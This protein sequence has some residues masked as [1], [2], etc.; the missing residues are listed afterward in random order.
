M[1]FVFPGQG[2]QKIGMGKDIYDAFP[3]ARDVFHEVDDSISFKLSNL[4][5][6][7]T[8]DE[9]KQTENA[10][11]ALMATSMA[12]V[13]ILQK[14]FGVDI[15]AKARF[16]AGHSLGE[17]TALCA[18]EAISI[19]DT[20][21][22]LRVRGQAM[23]RAFPQNGAMAAIIG[24]DLETVEQI[25]FECY[26]DEEIVQIANDNSVG[27][28]VISGHKNAVNRV[29][30]KASRFNV[31]MIMLD[32]SGPFHSKLMENAVEE[33]SEALEK[34]NFRCP[35]K[36]IISNI[37]AQAET[38]N[39]KELLIKQLTGRIRWRES[40]LWAESQAVSK[41]I[42]VGFG[43][44]LI[45]LIKRITPNMKLISIN[46]LGSLENFADY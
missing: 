4:I 16:L 20:A 7:G 29:M 23:S 46:S 27:Q 13:R 14:E 37:T 34:T 35:L 22:V 33:I 42:E 25:V 32:V 44:V 10:Q 30:E 40:I 36:P 38:N 31:K 11:P 17:Y 8:E 21:R 24:L 26:L 9:L 39:F 43:K 19:A 12:F 6:N 41:C 15:C 45:G 1:L 18:G 3:S 28:V 5:F 2:S